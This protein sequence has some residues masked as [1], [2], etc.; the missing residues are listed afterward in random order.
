MDSWKELCKWRPES[1]DEIMDLATS[2]R[3]EFV[4]S[5]G[6]AKN[7]TPQ[8]D[9]VYAHGLLFL[10][11]ALLLQVFQHAIKHGDPGLVLRVLKFWVYSF[12][13]AGST[14][15]ARECLE[16]FVQWNSGE[17]TEEAKEA[18][19]TS[20]FYNRWGKP[21]RFIASDQYLE[22]LNYWTKVGSSLLKYNYC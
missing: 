7:L 4:N 13:G 18:L 5:R 21:G 16:I 15:Y 2:I 10:R 3:R 8:G 9:H 6:A 20:W 12:R 11:D 14:N 22:H 17:L 19:E 1:A